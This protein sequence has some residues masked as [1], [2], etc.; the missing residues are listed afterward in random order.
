MLRIGKAFGQSGLK[1]SFTSEFWFQI[2]SL[3]PLR[4]STY[5]TS[6][7]VTKRPQDFIGYEELVQWA[8]S[9]IESFNIGF[10]WSKKLWKCCTVW[11]LLGIFSLQ[12]LQLGHLT[13]GKQMMRMRRGTERRNMARVSG[14]ERTGNNWAFARRS[15]RLLSSTIFQYRGAR[16]PVGRERQALRE[17]SARKEL[18]LIQVCLRLA[19]P[20]WWFC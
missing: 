4:R 20:P 12:I 17:S 2:L 14:R 8:L 13:R 18:P 5:A 9:S 6:K 16:T 15:A 19:C 11:W 3:G 7:R 10:L 1:S